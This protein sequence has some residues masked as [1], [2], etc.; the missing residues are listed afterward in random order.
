MIVSL[1]TIIE[2]GIGNGL[3]ELA[4]SI[5]IKSLVIILFVYLGLK[6]GRRLKPITQVTLLKSTF[7]ILLLLPFLITVAPSWR[8]PGWEQLSTPALSS[9]YKINVM[10]LGSSQ[11]ISN[12]ELH[13]DFATL[14]MAIYTIGAIAILFRLSMGW[15][16]MRRIIRRSEIVEI[17]DV[18]ASINIVPNS[19]MPVRKIAIAF[20]N[21]VS[22]PTVFGLINH[23][24]LFPE[25]AK[26]WDEDTLNMAFIHELA[27]IKRKDTLWYL[28]SS[29]TLALHWYNPFTWILRIKLMMKAEIVCDDFVLASGFDAHTYAEKI[30]G[31]ARQMNQK[32]FAI[33]SGVSMIKDSKLEDRLMSILCNRKRITSIKKLKVV[34]GVFMV[35][36][37]VLPFSGLQLLANESSAESNDSQDYDIIRIDSANYPD[38][39]EF[40]K[41]TTM[42]QFISTAPPVYPAELEKNNIEGSV[43]IKAMIDTNGAVVKAVINKTSGYKEFDL[44]ALKAAKKNRFTPALYEQKPVAMWIC[45]KVNFELEETE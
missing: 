6:V 15:Y 44:S 30:L 2:A 17:K 29:I 27:H 22:G 5:T 14:I 9:V 36:L 33:P 24:I 4:F 34:L 18:L 31:L 8:F 41:V 23:T 19:L 39:G 45:Y 43:Y 40:V 21:E 1:Q 37:L 28:I 3:A 26:K 20:S 12:S 13:L 32:R 38:P 35:A 11:S 7:I 10:S 25:E 16:F 42:P